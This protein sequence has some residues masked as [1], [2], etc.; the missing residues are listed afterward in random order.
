M[1]FCSECGGFIEE[2]AP[3]WSLHLQHEVFRDGEI[4]VLDAGSLFFLCEQCARRK[5]FREVQVQDKCYSQ[6]TIRFRKDF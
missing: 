3:L 1:I 6:A 4:T 2:G 5:D